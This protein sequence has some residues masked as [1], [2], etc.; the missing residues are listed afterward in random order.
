MSDEKIWQFIGAVQ[1][2]LDSGDEKFD[3]ILK[4]LDKID[5]NVV[6][7]MNSLNTHLSYHRTI[8]KIFQLALSVILG[9]LGYLKLLR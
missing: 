6:R 4:R 9:V 8:R 5:D 3:Q 2:R 7:C 1:S